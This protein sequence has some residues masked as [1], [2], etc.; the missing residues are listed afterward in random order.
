MQLFENAM[1]MF[2]PFAQMTRGGA[3]SAKPNASGAGA[4]PQGAENVKT[5]DIDALK[6]Q[7]NQMQSQLERL[8]KERG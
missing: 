2:N 7:L 6:S 1:R 3:A 4:T 8:M 5:Q